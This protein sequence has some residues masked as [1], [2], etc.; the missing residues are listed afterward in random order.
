MACKVPLS[1]PPP[2]TCYLPKTKYYLDYLPLCGLNRSRGVRPGLKHQSVL[3]SYWLPVFQNPVF[4][5][6]FITLP[7]L[8]LLMSLM[9]KMGLPSIAVL[10]PANPGQSVK[11]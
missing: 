6:N 1:P 11:I 4:R 9:L 5:A 2:P 7:I 10:R 8:K 3:I